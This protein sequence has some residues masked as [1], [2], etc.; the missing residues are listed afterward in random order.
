MVYSDYC[1]RQTDIEV[2]ISHATKNVK[3]YLKTYNYMVYD[4]FE[5]QN[6]TR[7]K[8]FIII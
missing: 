8:T 5:Q 3:F 1:V 2:Y 7:M 6:K 4:K